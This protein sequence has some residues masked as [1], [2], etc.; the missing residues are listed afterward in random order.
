MRG[1]FVVVFKW[2]GNYVDGILILKEDETTDRGIFINNS[3]LNVERKIYFLLT[4]K[5]G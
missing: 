3:L 1:N 4:P 2:K 5:D